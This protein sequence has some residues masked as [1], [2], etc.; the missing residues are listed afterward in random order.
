M[1]NGLTE[2]Y[3]KTKERLI[4]KYGQTLGTL[5]VVEAEL[6]ILRKCI[7]E[8]RT[9]LKELKEFESRIFNNLN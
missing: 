2:K 6:S 4:E 1:E 9:T 8:E 3:K 7:I 5:K